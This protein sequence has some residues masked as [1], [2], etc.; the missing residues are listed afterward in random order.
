MNNLSEVNLTIHP[1]DNLIEF[2]T[3]NTNLGEF[4]SQ[5]P[6]NI[7]GEN[8]KFKTKFNFKYLIEGMQQIPS[9]DIILQFSKNDSNKDKPLIL[10][11][12]ND[13]SFTYL[14]MPMRD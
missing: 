9:S 12:S 8:K 4:N 3:S 7:S 5:I 14:V 13:N 11:N 2:Q 6:V 10:K 1:E